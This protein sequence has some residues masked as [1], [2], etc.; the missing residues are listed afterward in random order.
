MLKISIK[1]NNTGEIRNFY[2]SDPI[3]E[4]LESYLF[5]WEEGNFSC[6]C[7]RCLFFKRVNN[8]L[9]DEASCGDEQY[10][11]NIYDEND[12]CIYSEF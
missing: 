7:N 9:E 3:D 8:E 12:K 10:S 5:L 2:D 4:D 11:V 1:C 6:D